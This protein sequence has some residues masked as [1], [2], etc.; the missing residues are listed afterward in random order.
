M[1]DIHWY[2]L[3]IFWWSLHFLSRF[4]DVSRPQPTKPPS[5]W[6]CPH[7]AAGS[8]QVNAMVRRGA[9]GQERTDKET[10]KAGT[11]CWHGL[12]MIGLRGQHI[13]NRN[14][15]YFQPTNSR[16]NGI[17]LAVS[18]SLAICVANSVRN[19]T[20]PSALNHL[21]PRMK[22]A[23]ILSLH[24]TSIKS[25]WRT[26][27]QQNKCSISGCLVQMLCRCIMWAFQKSLL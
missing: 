6:G 2:Y 4:H 15:W 24:V 10:N 17:K 12:A 14:I 5:V 26:L 8:E 7:F 19:R 18:H 23:H 3:I 22:H 20:W 1:Y 13:E 9:W 25:R 16:R 11:R 27:C 21:G